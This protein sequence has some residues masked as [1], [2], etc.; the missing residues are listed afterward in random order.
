VP[1][2]TVWMAPVVP[3]SMLPLLVDRLPLACG[4]VTLRV[5]ADGWDVEGLPEGLELVREPRPLPTRR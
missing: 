5:S 2:G 1:A 4:E 3:D